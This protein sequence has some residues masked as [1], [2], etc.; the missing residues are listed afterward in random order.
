MKI[1]MAVLAL[2][3]V[4]AGVF[5]Y[6]RTHN[7]FPSDLRDAVAE[8]PGEFNTSIPVF[9]KDGGNMPVPIISAARPRSAEDIAIDEGLYVRVYMTAV[10]IDWANRLSK[11]NEIACSVGR[12]AS[13]FKESIAEFKNT[14]S[15]PP[16]KEAFETVLYVNEKVL[17]VLEESARRLGYNSTDQKKFEKLFEDPYN[18]IMS[19]MAYMT[20]LSQARFDAA[21]IASGFVNGTN[22]KGGAF[23]EKGFFSGGPCGILSF[24]ECQ[25]AVG[26][27]RVG[28]QYVNN[29]LFEVSALAHRRLTEAGIYSLTV[30]PKQYALA[31]AAALEEF[32]GDTGIIRIKPPDRASFETLLFVNGQMRRVYDA[33]AL[34]PELY[35]YSAK[36][37]DA[38]AKATRN[39]ETL[40]EAKSRVKKIVDKFVNSTIGKPPLD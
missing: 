6:T 7:V 21:Y 14:P 34:R 1:R 18:R 33:V 38:I 12:A 23:A 17:L 39:A 15:N 26:I 28:L 25:A 22:L 27:E 24:S 10:Q 20:T 32:G 11:E 29:Y 36:P 35:S 37:L 2:L 31:Y 3:A 9:E 8:K 19:A 40:N 16:T 30:T 5:V 13:L 4:T